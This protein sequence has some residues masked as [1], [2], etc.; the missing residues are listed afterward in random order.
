MLSYEKIAF[1]DY[2]LRKCESFDLK[3][4]IESN[5]S[6]IDVFSKKLNLNKKEVV[7][8]IRLHAP[9]FSISA[10]DSDLLVNKIFPIVHKV[11]KN[12]KKNYDSYSGLCGVDILKKYAT[13]LI[14]RKINGEAKIVL[15]SE[16]GAADERIKNNNGTLFVANLVIKEVPIEVGEFLEN[17]LHYL[18]TFRDDAFLRIGLFIEGYSYPICYMS[19]ASI[20]RADKVKAL[21][22]SLDLKVNAESVVELSRVYGC[23]V[24]PKNTISYMISYAKR[25]LKNYIYLI[26][27]VNINLG[28]SGISMISS[29]FVPYALRPVKY[30]YD[31][32]GC[33]MTHRK[34]PGQLTNATE[35]MPPNILYV[36]EICNQYGADKR[37]CRL[38]SIK[39]KKL[40]K[41]G[42]AIELEISEIRTKLE[43]VWSKNTCYHGTKFSK[44]HKVSKGQCGVSSLHLALMLK[45]KGYSV[46]FCEGDFKFLKND[47]LSILNHCWIVIKNYRNRHKDVVVDITADQNGYPQKIVFKDDIELRKQGLV[48]EAKT[49]RDPDEVNVEHLLRRL[50][51]LE[52][53][54][55]KITEDN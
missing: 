10:L 44:E 18:H 36:K 17:E 49:L 13:P 4:L 33:Y 31:V 8:Q 40:E 48:Y 12:Y 45:S 55:N 46:Y 21:R 29:G 41:V 7:R 30:T 11:L 22:K 39:T 42:S 6:E 2:S 26:T 43:K 34:H 20:D 38:I 47:N 28:F 25:Y 23:G 50:N 35:K 52:K 37:Y 53:S 24:L 1:E 51:Y 15:G 3:M 27:A 9:Q 5:Q 32:N 14:I 16:Q 54:L 19:F